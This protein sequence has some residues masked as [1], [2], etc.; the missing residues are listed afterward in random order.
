MAA[1]VGREVSVAEE[2]ARKHMSGV[3]TG[4]GK[5]VA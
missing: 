3:A 5:K 2:V 4:M 1:M